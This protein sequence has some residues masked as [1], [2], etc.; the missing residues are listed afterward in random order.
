VTAIPTL[1]TERLRLRAFRAADWDAYAAMCADEE[2]MRHIGAG[3]AVSANDAWRQI[4]GMLG[5]W[6]LRGCGQWAVE[7][8]SDG[9][10]LGRVG[11]IDPPGWPGFEIGWLLAREHW[12]QGYAR[13]AAR[14]AMRYAEDV[15]G[16]SECIHLIRPDNTR[17]LALATALGATLRETIEFM[18]GTAQVHVSC[19]TALRATRD[20]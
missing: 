15:L 7:R 1:T 6:A 5:H 14:A 2:V 11:A 3:G 16:R 18:G 13:E 10:L 8:R 12:G 9:A 17:S 20:A 4:A 19:S